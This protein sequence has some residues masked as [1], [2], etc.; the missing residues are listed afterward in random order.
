MAG[1]KKNQQNTSSK[2]GKNKRSK[3]ASRNEDSDSEAMTR[4]KRSRSRS[5]SRCCRS[6]MQDSMNQ[7]N[8][9]RV[10]FHEEDVEFELEVDAD[11]DEFLQD[12]DGEI[13]IA[14]GDHEQVIEAIV[15]R[16]IEDGEL[17][18][19]IV[20]EQMP[21]YEEEF[22]QVVEP[23]NMNSSSNVM[24]STSTAVPIGE[25]G[26]KE[27]NL[28]VD[29]AVNKTVEK[30]Q[31]LMVKGLFGRENLQKIINGTENDERRGGMSAF[32]EQQNSSAPRS[33]VTMATGGKHNYKIKQSSGQPKK[34]GK[35]YSRAQNKGNS[36]E[37][38]RSET[39]IYE[40]AVLPLNNEE[41]N[42][43]NQMIL[44]SSS[45]GFVDT[46]DEFEEMKGAR[47][48][49][50]QMSNNDA[51]LLNNLIDYN[52]NLARNQFTRERRPEVNREEPQPSTSGYIPPNRR[53]EQNT[54]PRFD[55]RRRPSQMA[56]N[57][58]AEQMIREAENAKVKMMDVPGNEIPLSI[59]EQ[60]NEKESQDFNE[61]QRANLMVDPN[62]HF[63]HSA[64][65]DE[66]FLM[67]AAHVDEVTRRRIV[68]GEFV[69]FARLLPREQ[70]QDFEEN[71][72]HMVNRDGQMFWVSAKPNQTISSFS[73]WEQA[74][75]VFSD[76]YTR[77]HPNRAVELIQYN[78][79]I[80]IASA[81]YTWENVY[82]Y[83]RDFRLHMSRHP[84]RS[85]AIILQ[86]S[87]SVRLRDRL[88]YENNSDRNFGRN[89]NKKR[90]VCWR[91]NRGK[92][93][94]GLN[95]K[96]DHRCSNCNKFGHGAHNCRRSND[97]PPQ[98]KNN[99]QN[100]DYKDKD[101]RDY[102]NNGSNK[103]K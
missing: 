1:G 9:T 99:H 10:T 4:S 12:S 65:V 42:G 48:S 95:C 24:P 58:R 19:Q 79:L 18:E 47:N 44:T 94:Y 85:W 27:K 77:S 78:H 16:E 54:V 57:E 83:D 36:N 82:M 34:S 40:N 70:V 76:I 30:I 50:V 45:E 100:H 53:Q 15:H 71:R 103:T 31:E 98:N 43:Q 25:V 61:N 97:R 28:I 59:E 35:E 102:G 80:Q 49:H 68:N 93:S 20:D 26:E 84:Q 62:N 33:T 90:D 52:L 3:S 23:V 81:S 72:M 7:R 8:A 60:G 63:V 64:M 32:Q 5:A 91:F 11:E 38:L 41:N 2:K 66:E 74:F 51:E 13:D 29:Q 88:R 21:S 75:K 6:E 73:R 39:T 86:Q 89:N 87:W 14:D 55:N 46:S 67:V 56:E 22:E 17:E 92:C 69:D 101:K 37:S 96:Y